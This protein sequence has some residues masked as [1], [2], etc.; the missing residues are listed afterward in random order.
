MPWDWR[1]LDNERCEIPFISITNRADVSKLTTWSRERSKAKVFDKIDFDQIVMDASMREHLGYIIPENKT[2]LNMKGIA[3]PLAASLPRRVPL[4][5][6]A[7]RPIEE[8]PREVV[9]DAE[10]K[11]LFENLEGYIPKCSPTQDT[12]ILPT[13]R[14][15]DELSP[16]QSS[17]SSRQDAVA[18]RAVDGPEVTESVSE[19]TLKVVACGVKHKANRKKSMNWWIMLRLSLLWVSRLSLPTKSL[20]FKIPFG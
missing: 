2:P 10:A 1:L 11:D 17:S 12:M 16:T 6:A 9:S 14:L 4:M 5:R 20:G 8:I 13:F 7:K 18:S 15:V 3:K 19:V